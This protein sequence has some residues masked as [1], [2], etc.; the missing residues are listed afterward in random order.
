MTIVSWIWF[1]LVGLGLL[2]CTV[3]LAIVRAD[4]RKNKR[5]YA[6][7]DKGRGAYLFFAAVFY[8]WFGFCLYDFNR[9]FAPELSAAEFWRSASAPEIATAA[10]TFTIAIMLGVYLS[11]TDYYPKHRER[12]YLSMVLLGIMS[13][14]G[15]ASMIFIINAAIAESGE[16]RLRLLVFFVMGMLMFIYGQKLLRSRLIRMTNNMV[17]DIRMEILDNVLNAPYENVEFMERGSIEACLNNDTERVSAF[18]N[19]MVSIG[20]WS[21]TIIAGFVYLALISWAGFLLS[22][23]VVIAASAAFYTIIRSANQLWEQTRS[24]QNVFFKFIHDL[25]YGFKELYLSRN[26]A[27]DFR[28]DMGNISA[29]YRDKRIGAEAKIANVVVIGDL[30][31]AT[32]IGTVVFAFPF[33]FPSMPAGSLRS[34]VFVFLYMAGPLTSILNSLPELFQA[35]ISWRRIQRF[36]EELSVFRGS[37]RQSSEPQETSEV[38]LRLEEAVYVY[39]RNDEETFVVGPIDYEF[40]SGELI[41]IVGGNGSGKSTLAKLITGLYELKDG[42]VT[43]NGDRINACD[44]GSHVSTIFSDAYLFERLYGIDFAA[45]E[46]EA[47]H[48]LQ[49]LGLQDKVS[50][51]DGRFSTTRLSTGQRKRLALLVSYL[52]DKPICLFD[53]WAADQDPEYR[54]FFYTVLLSDLRSR[55]KCV[56]VITHDDRYFGL[57]DKLIKLEMGKIA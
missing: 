57:A 47:Q 46:Q 32:V 11:L 55:G 28:E 24:I 36:S 16:I 43:L 4:I 7:S 37:L 20:T 22:L 27:R 2:W 26:K 17:Y 14:L 10:A 1:G 54:E 12:P 44:I 48:Y 25:I 35:R 3:C 56:I 45:K 50:I 19:R 29:S 40:C 23:F 9:L 53:E 5:S 13:G 51:Q 38:T 52:D 6:K 21:V 31:F 30:L 41:F 49:L 8:G 15:N 18:A 33:L 42:N 39:G 34:F